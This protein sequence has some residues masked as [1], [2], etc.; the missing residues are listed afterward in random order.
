[1][2]PP[3]PVRTRKKARKGPFWGSK[4]G[5]KKGAIL[6]A[7]GARGAPRGPGKILHPPFFFPGFFWVYRPGSETEIFGNSRN[8]HR[9]M[10]SGAQRVSEILKNCSF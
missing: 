9:K 1:M 8:L 10:H 2:G 3:E 4:K 6:G 5:P 7:P